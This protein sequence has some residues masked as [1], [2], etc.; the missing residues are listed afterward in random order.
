MKAK[1][2]FEKNSLGLISDDLLGLISDDL[3][4]IKLLAFILTSSTLKN[5]ALRV[6]RLCRM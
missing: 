4:I 5:E 2:S 6:F 3:L 1:E